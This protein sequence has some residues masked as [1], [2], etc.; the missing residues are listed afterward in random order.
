LNTLADEFI[1]QAIEARLRTTEKIGDWLGH[2]LDGTRAKLEH[3][4][5]ALQTYAGKSGLIF[6][7]T[8]TADDTNIETEKLQQ[9]QVAL[10]TQ[11]ADRVA[12]EARNELAQHAPPNTLADVLN[13]DN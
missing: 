2:E 4:E 7:T 6:T 12:K 13:D 8:S 1:G 11:I 10:T 9:L 5:A 3:S